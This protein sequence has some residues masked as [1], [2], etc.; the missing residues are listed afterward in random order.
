LLPFSAKPEKYD[1]QIADQ[2][3]GKSIP[4]SCIILLVA[5]HRAIIEQYVGMD[6][7]V[8]A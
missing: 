8:M 1:Y 3:V 4:P 6:L 2:E 7:Y 5:I